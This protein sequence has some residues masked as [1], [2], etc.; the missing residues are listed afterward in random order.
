MKEREFQSVAA[1]TMVNDAASAA[2]EIFSSRRVK[3][4]KA[5][6]ALSRLL[7]WVGLACAR[8]ILCPEFPETAWASVIRQITNCAC[9]RAVFARRDVVGGL[10]GGELPIARKACLI[11]ISVSVAPSIMCLVFSSPVAAPSD[12]WPS[13]REF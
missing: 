10:G 2:G 11:N 1:P 13:S 7:F 9:G 6:R 12:I 8:H 4:L 3:L 5:R